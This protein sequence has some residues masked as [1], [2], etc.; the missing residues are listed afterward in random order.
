MHL[1]EV[2]IHEAFQD[3]NA[4]MNG[5]QAQYKLST[6]NRLFAKKAYHFLEDYLALTEKFYSASAAT[7]DFS[8]DLKLPSL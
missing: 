2:N 7:M 8:G 3:H 5:E 1:E 4:V 6:A